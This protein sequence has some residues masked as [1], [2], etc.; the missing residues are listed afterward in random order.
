[1]IGA[2]KP[3]LAVVVNGGAID[4]MGVERADVVLE[5]AEEKDGEGD[6]VVAMETVIVLT[7]A[8]T[9]LLHRKRQQ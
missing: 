5:T 9:E 3:V 2:Q 8:E 4:S 7:N 1:M 6:L